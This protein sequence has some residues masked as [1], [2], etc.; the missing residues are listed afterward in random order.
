MSLPR[1]VRTGIRVLLS[2]AV[3]VGMMLWLTGRFRTGEIVPGQLPPE[4]RSAAGVRT[5][6]VRLTR[7]PLISE[8]V[9]TVQPEYKITVSARVSA[10]IVELRARAGQA[11]GKDDRVVRL[12]DRDLRARVDQAKE[13][14]RHA[15]ATRDLA[16]IDY[17]RFKQLFADGAIARQQFDQG[18]MQRKAATAD[19]MHAREIVREA[20]VALSYAEIRSP[21][22]GV[23]IDKLADVGDL[24]LPGKTLLTLYEPG[25]LWLEVSVREQEASRLRIGQR[26]QVKL[27]ASGLQTAGRLVEIVPSADPASRTVTARVALPDI[28]GLYPG[29]FGRLL[30]PVGEAESVFIPQAAVIRVGQLTMVEV[31]TDGVLQ[32]RTIQTGASGDGRIEV[33]SGLTPGETIALPQPARVTP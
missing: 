6:P 32:R 9:G 28:Q 2:L 16:E 33:L 31:I 22:A 21:V 18:D 20:E 14:L 7:L 5:S 13:A 30:I 11:V 29:T 19:V 25:R 27:D 23:V 26:Y 3:I 24:A 15:E 1:V 10:N 17:G 12:D 4:T 8:A